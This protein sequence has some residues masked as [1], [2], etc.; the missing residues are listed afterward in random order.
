MADRCTDLEQTIAVHFANSAHESVGQRILQAERTANR[1]K[2]YSLSSTVF[3]RPNFT[4]GNSTAG[5]LRNAISSACLRQ[6]LRRGRMRRRS[7]VSPWLF[8]SAL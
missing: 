6:S 5:I 8:L 3:E 4:N 2:P 7:L 1:V